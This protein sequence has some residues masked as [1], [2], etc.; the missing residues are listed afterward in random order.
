MWSWN[1]PPTTKKRGSGDTGTH[2]D[3]LSDYWELTATTKLPG[4]LVQLKVC[5][6]SL[7]L[8][9]FFYCFHSNFISGTQI[10]VSWVQI[11]GRKCGS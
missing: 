5:L 1:P 2:H 9:L 8:T 11:V 6:K 4:P 10:K 7:A 3:S